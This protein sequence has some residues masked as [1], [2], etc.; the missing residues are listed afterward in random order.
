MTKVLSFFFFDDVLPE[1]NTI[2]ACCS[3]ALIK[4]FVIARESHMPGYDSVC[5]K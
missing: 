1:A 3:R 5:S 4:I 2:C